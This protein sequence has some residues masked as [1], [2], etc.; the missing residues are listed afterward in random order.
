[1]SNAISGSLGAAGAGATVVLSGAASA[2][3]TA[4][5]GTGNYSFT[6]L[7][8]GT[9]FITPGLT[10]KAFSPT[11]QTEVIVATDITGVNFDTFVPQHTQAIV[12]P[13]GGRVEAAARIESPRTSLIGTDFGT[14][15]LG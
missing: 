10:G 4:A 2:S 7:G 12:Q 6:G 3:T 11:S 1:M 15:V 8:A 14:K 13:G 9:Y 5:A